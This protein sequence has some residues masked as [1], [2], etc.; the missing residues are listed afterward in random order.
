MAQDILAQNG[1]D[2]KVRMIEAWEMYGN[3]STTDIKGENSL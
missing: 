3:R 2:E 1:Y